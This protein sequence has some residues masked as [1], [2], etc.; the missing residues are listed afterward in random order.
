M[1]FAG[2]GPERAATAAR[3]GASP[4][5]GRGVAAPVSGGPDWG[6]EIFI[7]FITAC[8]LA[9]ILAVTARR[10]KVAPATL[11]ISARAGLVLRS[12][13]VRGGP[14]RRP[15]PPTR[16]PQLAQK[17]AAPGSS[18][19]HSVQWVTAGASPWPQLMQNFAPAGFE[20][21]QDAH[22]TPAAACCA[23]GAG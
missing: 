3:P 9:V 16:V 11:A 22:A 10:S 17:R 8:Y 5:R 2:R 1:V 21:W 12:R 19:P 14:A 18:V 4:R 6:G 13:D 23:V 15:Q 20:A 7:L